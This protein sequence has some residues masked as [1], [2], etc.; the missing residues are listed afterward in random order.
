[1]EKLEA[2]RASLEGA[3]MRNKE[4]TVTSHGIVGPGRETYEISNSAQAAGNCM[5]NH[6]QFLFSSIWRLNTSQIKIFNSGWG[7][8]CA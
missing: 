1:M 3:V 6:Q 2:K 5:R 4:D 8:V 7:S